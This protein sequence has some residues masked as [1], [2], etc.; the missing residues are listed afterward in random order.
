MGAASPACRPARPERGVRRPGRA[1]AAR[2]RPDQPRCCAGDRLVARRPQLRQCG[3]ADREL[4]GLG[5]GAL[6]V[7]R[8]G[9]LRPAPPRPARVDHDAGRAG[10]SGRFE[11]PAHRDSDPFTAGCRSRHGGRSGPQLP[12]DP[13]VPL[14]GGRPARRGRGTWAGWTSGCCP[15]SRRCA[16]DRGSR[17]GGGALAPRPNPAASLGRAHP[18]GREHG[19]A[20]APR[21]A[22][23]AA[24]SHSERPA[25]SS[26][27]TPSRATGDG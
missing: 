5:L 24:R 10:P 20:R 7:R 4:P 17:G 21:P 11:A 15:H 23:R 26:C 9:R 19:G 13:G 2:G 14:P 3:T 8:S 25:A 12:A 18:R 22:G 1:A 16:R 6:R 27:P